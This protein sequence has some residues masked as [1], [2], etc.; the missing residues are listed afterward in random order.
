MRAD[1][2]VAAQRLHVAQLILRLRPGGGGRNIEPDQLL[3]I[4]HAPAGQRQRQIGEIGLADFRC[5]KARQP[6]L[7][8]LRPEP[9][10]MTSS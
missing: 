7:G 5:G 9:Q 4:A 6:L 1:A 3:R 8:I 10:A 2:V